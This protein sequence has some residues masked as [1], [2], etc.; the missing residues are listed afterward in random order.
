MIVMKKLLLRLSVLAA[1]S[2][3]AVILLAAA[4]YERE[5]VP[6]E[7]VFMPAIM[8]HSVCEK[9]PADYVVTPRQFEQ[10][11]IWLKENGFESVTEQQLIGYTHGKCSLPEKPVLITLDDGFY[12]NYSEVLPLL[13]KYDMYAVVSVVGEYTEVNAPADPH[14]PEYSYLTWED[15]AAMR[16]SAHFGIGNHTYSMH[17]LSGGRKGCSRN[18]GEPLDSYCMAIR[19]DIGLLQTQLKMNAGFVPVVFAYPFGAVS[20]ESLPVLRDMGF[21]I[22]LNCSERPNL[23]TRDPDCLYGICRY[24]RSGLYDTASFMQRATQH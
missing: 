23:I 7:A 18:E 1:I 19:S 21:L 4:L 6:E 24:N 14:I 20:R 13:E 5:I 12:N 17:S 22:T 11:M 9:A 8:Y 10:D 2:I 3:T 16:D 15:I